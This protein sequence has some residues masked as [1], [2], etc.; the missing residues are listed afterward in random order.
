MCLR[1]MLLP[2][3][4]QGCSPTDLADELESLACLQ[5]K[6]G[7]L[8]ALELE[9]QT[10]VM[11]NADRLFSHLGSLC[12]SNERKKGLQRRTSPSKPEGASATASAAA[13]AV[14]S[15]PARPE[16]SPPGVPFDSEHPPAA[17]SAA[18][19][20]GGGGGREN[21]VTGATGAHAC[22]RT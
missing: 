5:R 13:S 10:E 6:I 15:C 21:A 18:A 17:T 4:D 1:N 9:R 19:G 14:A 22:A 3:G 20:G 16:G 8:Q 7:D 11:E 12:S 2:S